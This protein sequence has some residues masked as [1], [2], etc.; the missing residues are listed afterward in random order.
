MSVR[1]AQSITV[2]F[3]T[4]RFD[5]GAA[6]NADS[7]PGGTL[8]LNGTD[9]AASVTVT[10]KATGIYKA[11]V[12][13]PTLA[14]NDVVELRIAATVNS[15]S[16][17]GIIWR[18]TKDVFAGAIP[19]VS[20]GGTNGLFIAGTNA[21]TTVTTSFTTTFT[22]NLTGS[23]GSVT[24]VS[25]KTGYSLA[26]GSFVTATFGTCDFTSTMKTSIGTAVAASAVASVTGNVGGNV[27]GSVGSVVGAVGSVTGNVGG[28]VVGSVASVTGAVGS[29]TGNVGG[30]VVGTV[31]STLALGSGAIVAASFAT[32]SITSTALA[33]SA[34]TEIQNGLS[35]LTAAQVNAE[36]DAAISDAALAT[37]AN[38]ATLT[39]YVDTEVAAIKAKTDNLPSDPA[40]ESLIIAATDAIMT[41]IGANGAGLTALGDTRIANL[42]ALVSS[43]MATFTL[44][45]N[46]AS[47]SLTAGGL[48]T[49]SPTA[50]VF[51][52][53]TPDAAFFTNA[54]AGSGLTAQQTRDAMKLA[55]SSGAP[56]AGSIDDKLDNLA[57][58]SGDGAFTITVTV[59]DGAAPLQNAHIRVSDGVT[60]ATGTTNVSGEAEFALD[61]ATYSVA[62]TKA[63]YQF[64]PTTRTVTGEEAG[65]LTNDLAMS[66]V[67]IPPSE[68]PT[69]CRLYMGFQN[70]K[71][72]RTEGT[73]TV[74]LEND[75]AS[76]TDATFLS[77][78]VSSIWHVDGYAY[79]DVPLSS[80]ITP[81]TG[82]YIAK[83]RAARYE[84]TISAVGT[85]LNLGTRIV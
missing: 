32:D 85:T 2:D 43:R 18:D 53:I 52:G 36:A 60:P 68:D 4:R 11:A 27:T 78:T 8:V 41:R 31:A 1:S 45:T 3:T 25:D 48:V 49:L 69:I 33:A 50:N 40:D 13:L 79:C 28:N 61:A 56:S 80:E 66:L 38:L 39:A 9:N 84:E 21:A 70:L 73:F 5:T 37:A 19:D 67:V 34:V 47:F 72:V 63:G 55:A 74:E 81:V 58:G 75:V 62:V 64:T 17:N 51:N 16:D 44:P 76:K 42:D 29:V 14:V 22:G 77:A 57:A 82:K 10:N 35:T 59:T 54:A 65:T 46:F 15:I 24:T 30:N 20:A 7:T 71:G 12:T 6:T 23:V 83:C 26:N